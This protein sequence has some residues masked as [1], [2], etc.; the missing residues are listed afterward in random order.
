MTAD[1][2]AL[3][4]RNTYPLAGTNTPTVLAVTNRTHS[5]LAGPGATGPDA[6]DAIDV[7]PADAVDAR[8]PLPAIESTSGGR[9]ST[10]GVSA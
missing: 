2:R 4:A 3:I 8:P 5:N 9:L 7:A 6:A 10:T 1:R